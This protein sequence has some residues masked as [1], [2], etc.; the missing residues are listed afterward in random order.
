MPTNKFKCACGVT[1]RKTGASATK[2]LF[3][4]QKGVTTNGKK[5]KR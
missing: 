5:K 3:K 1:T 2:A 4:K